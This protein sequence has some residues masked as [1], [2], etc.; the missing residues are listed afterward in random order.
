M[1]QISISELKANTEKYVTFADKQD[2]YIR[3]NGKRI[4]KI[5]SVKNDKTTAVKSLF[6]ILPADTNLD[7]EREKRLK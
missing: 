4:A 1:M 2:I 5:T 3:K 6:R 7:K